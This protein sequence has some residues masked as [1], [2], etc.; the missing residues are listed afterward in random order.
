MSIVLVK[1]I[2]DMS[3]MIYLPSRI[4]RGLTGRLPVFSRSAGV[5]D[6][7]V[8]IVKDNNLRQLTNL[9]VVLA[10]NVDNILQR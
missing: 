3:N 7:V 9:N 2:A 8:S 6:S 1:Q 4:K 5:A 10:D